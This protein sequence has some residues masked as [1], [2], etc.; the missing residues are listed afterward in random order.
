MVNARRTYCG[1][2]IKVDL[3]NDLKNKVNYPIHVL[4]SM[5]IPES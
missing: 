5:T 3:I 1:Y 4:W 2:P